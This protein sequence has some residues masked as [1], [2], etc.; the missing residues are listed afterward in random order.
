MDDADF[1][2]RRPRGRGRDRPCDFCRERKVACVIR[3]QP[4]CE[5][6]KRCH[7]SCTFA[8]A[9]PP[10]A[11]D[12]STPFDTQPKIHQ[13]QSLVE[14]PEGHFDHDWTL[15]SAFSPALPW[16]QIFD[17]PEFIDHG[18][19]SYSPSWIT[20]PQPLRPENGNSRRSEEQ[21]A[22][23]GSDHM[24]ARSIRSDGP[25]S[26]PSPYARA[27]FTS[28][29]LGLTAE[30]DPLLRLRYKFDE[31]GRFMSAIRGFH[32]LSTSYEPPVL[33]LLTPQPVSQEMADH[34]VPRTSS[35]VYESLSEYSS[36]LIK[37]FLR[38]VQPQY[39][40]LIADG[41]LSN[42]DSRALL[43]MVYSLALSWRSYD[44]DLPWEQFNLKAT[45]RQEHPD[46]DLIQQFAWAE[47]NR[48]MHA[49][50]YSALA[51]C[52]LFIE[53]NRSN[54]FIADTAFDTCVVANA[55]SLAFSLGLHIDCHGWNTPPKEKAYRI[56]LWWIVYVQDRWINIIQ[57][58][59]PRIR[60]E[61]FNVRPLSSTNDLSFVDPEHK[62][63]S[64]FGS[65]QT[66]VL[67]YHLLELTMALD[68]IYASLL[69]GLHRHV[70]V[71]RALLTSLIVV[72]QETWTRFPRQRSCK[73]S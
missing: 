41:A 60:E 55:V 2:G 18:A 22:T 9:P 65:S 4:P 42:E 47:I 20:Q 70:S 64:S 73:D 8:K 69:Y 14:P 68:D 21:N 11:T 54:M 40:V 13:M 16:E 36:S 50:D 29:Y 66:S 19:D 34:V 43:T 27:H 44:P 26:T 25:H 58:Q 67:F 15:T 46:E 12:R 59:P 28:R 51:A 45:T 31:N 48:E 52:L 71:L 57:G 62:R 24:P 33:A 38:F 72:L 35:S 56:L 63:D 1:A 39:P 3:M 32:R 7:R 49:P 10:R 37:L 30:M 53:R 6:C 5:K 17:D 61:D 23:P